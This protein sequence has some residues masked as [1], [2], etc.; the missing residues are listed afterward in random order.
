[1]IPG[2]HQIISCPHCKG[3]AKHKTLKSG[4]TLMAT[5]RR[6]RKKIFPMMPLPPSVVK[7]QHCDKGYWLVDAEKVGT[8]V[9]DIWGKKNQKV[10]PEWAAAKMVEEP[11][12]LE[13]YS[14][15]DAKLA[16]TPQQEKTLRILAWCRRNDAYCTKNGAN[17]PVSDLCRANIEALL[18][19][20]DLEKEED[21][22]MKEEIIRELGLHEFP[23]Q[24]DLIVHDRIKEVLI[25]DDEEPLLL[26]IADGLNIYKNIFNLLTA[27]DGSEAIKVLKASPVIALVVTGLYMPRM[28]GFELFTHIKKHYPKT[29]VILMTG[30]N[31]P[32]I[33]ERAR[34]MGFFSFLAKPLDIEILADNIF[35]ALEIKSARRRL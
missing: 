2:P 7:C 15:I 18:T 16:I 27:T 20:L 32:A 30:M 3:L 4:N 9:V 24:D 21:R 5:V 19:M 25:V 13:Y 29:P 17:V 23:E 26:S 10:N 28:D 31:E 34:T 33:K 22:L 1:M 6:D 11:S 14:L 12:E 8:V 35:A